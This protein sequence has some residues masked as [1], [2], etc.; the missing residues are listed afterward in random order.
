MFK[1]EAV[2]DS[3]T[4]SIVTSAVE[5][6]SYDRSG[7]GFVN[8]TS[9]GAYNEDGTLKDNA[10]V[11]YITENTKDTVSL[12]VVTGSKGE[13]TSYT[14]LQAILYGFKKGKDSRPLDVRLVGNI[15][16]LKSMDKG[17]I[18][19]DGCKTVSHLKVSAKMQRQTAGDSALKD[20]QMLK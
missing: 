14:G 1:V 2:T 4:A 12:D 17:D 19:I 5:V 6:M 16:D 15:T 18:V 9:S 7:Y 8:G 3:T 11:L 20:L 13:V 10:V